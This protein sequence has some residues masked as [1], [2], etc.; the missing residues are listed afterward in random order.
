MNINHHLDEA[1]LFSYVAGSLSQGM[2]LVVACHISICDVCRGRVLETESIGGALLDDIASDN[3]SE[4]F[5]DDALKQVLARLDEE[6]PEVSSD[7]KV[8]SR[9][10]SRGDVPAPLSD[11]IGSSLESIHWKR[12]APG[13]FYYDVCKE[14][15]G[16]CRLLKVAP[17]K[18]LL[19]HGH[20]GNELTLLLRGSYED[21]MGHYTQGDVVDVDDQVEHQAL[22]GGDE[23][24]IC[25][26]ATDSPLRFTT[27]W[28][29]ILQ[30]I[31]GF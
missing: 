20:Q 11:Y 3:T 13:F 7:N 30:P 28:G 25:L 16:I 31:S 22:I 12:L 18:S 15:Q 10:I 17:G 21:Q 5:S 19:P 24:C 29:K 27:L 8:T 14:Q 2:A 4:Q 26:L 6:E 1:T 23:D 9:L